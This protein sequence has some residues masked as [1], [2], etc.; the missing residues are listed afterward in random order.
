MYIYYDENGGDL[1]ECRLKG[2]IWDK[3]R[4]LKEINTS[5]GEK[6]A[7]V[8]ADGQILF[9]TSN[10]DGGQGGVDIYWSHLSPNGKWG[11]PENLGMVV[12]TEY[13]E[14]GVFF[15]PDGKTLYFSSKG[16]DNMGGYDIFKTVLQP[17]NSW[18]KPENL[19]YPINTTSD[20]IYFVLSANGLTGYYSSL[21]D[22]GVGEKDIFKISM[23]LA[24]KKK[25][26]VPKKPLTANAIPPP[27]D[28]P[29]TMMKG[30]ISDA[31]TKQPV[32]ASIQVVGNGGGSPRPRR[33]RTTCR[34]RRRAC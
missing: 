21:R 13:D 24:M 6:S 14:D 31:V 23:P 1:Y 18:S 33:R 10:R 27:P 8:S 19:G 29:L 9:F 25:K 28:N 26:P 5:A 22:D 2:D 12:N 15:H 34:G 17:D 11:K 20:D 16:H 3:P 7:A 32:A 4:P 30:T